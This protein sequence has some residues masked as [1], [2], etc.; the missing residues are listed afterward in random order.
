VVQDVSAVVR[1]LFEKNGNR[2]QVECPNNIGIMRADITKLRQI[3]FNLLGNANKF[4]GNGAVQLEVQRVVSGQSA[5][6]NFRVTDTGIGMTPEQLGRLFEAFS[7]ADTST[8]R[9]YG[10]TGLGLAI[11]KKF[12][13]LMGGDLAAESVA[14]QGSTFTLSLPADVA[15]PSV[16]MSRSFSADLGL[17][18][19]DRPPKLDGAC[20]LVIDD[21]P[22]V[23][24]LMERTLVQE[25]YQVHCAQN[26]PDG[27]ELARSIKPSAI[28]LDV[29]MPGMDGWTVL[30]QLKADPDLAG[31]PVVMLTIADDRDL[32]FSLG[33]ADFLTKPIHWERLRAV[34]QRLRVKRGAAGILVVDD[35]PLIRQLLERNLSREGWTVRL[36]ENGKA[37]LEEVVREVP[38]VILL[39]LMMPVM[40][41]FEFL[42]ELRRQHS[43]QEIP[44]IVITSMDLSDQDKLQLSSQVVRILEKSR[45]P[46]DEL[47]A[48]VRLLLARTVDWEI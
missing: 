6:M 16:E 18:M 4:T 37:G 21:D 27:L 30:S 36:A 26:G 14:G 47:L 9:K 10:G 41:G 35:D 25:G 48:E 33:A 45:T 5:A 39:D 40:S 43:C 13:Q 46:T 11:S 31:I 3:L 23:R 20:L 34:L 22:A 1:P 44:V 7:Q 12:C 19:A 32:G 28:T 17:P 2:L 38:G 24:N 8:A 29:M 42:Q 15:P